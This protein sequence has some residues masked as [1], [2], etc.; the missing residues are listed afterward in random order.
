[1]SD[2]LIRAASE[3][4]DDSSQD[5][6]GLLSYLEDKR[7]LLEENLSKSRD[8]QKRLADLA[9]DY[10]ERL[11][12]LN[13]NADK[14][15]KEARKEAL[16][17]VSEA[18]TTV[19]GLVSEIRETQADKKS[20]K[21]A[22]D[23]IAKSK[24]LLEEK[25]KRDEEVQ[26]VLPGEVKPGQW[27]RIVSLGKEAKVIS[28][29]DSERVFMEFEGGIRVE[30]SI[31]D[32]V[33]LTEKRETSNQRKVKWA[34]SAEPV[35][36]EIMIR[37]L[38]KI[39]ALEMVDHLIDRAVLQGLGSVRIIHGIGKGILKRAVYNRLRKDPRVKDIH[40]GEPA[41]GGDGVAVVELK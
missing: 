32:I 8:M 37:G 12:Y 23:Q 35:Y 38:E 25:V 16:K 9:T 6:E 13:K 18:R 34:A 10:G 4:L 19:E 26:Y 27:M 41:I 20:I 3:K 33:P 29:S 11:N 36:P 31:E 28:V 39:E 30:T 5:L 22:K 17:V 14:Y 1:L 2:D 15:E 7:Q 24:R 40:P 21:R